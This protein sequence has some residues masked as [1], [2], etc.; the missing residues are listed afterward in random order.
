MFVDDRL[1]RLR[2][3]IDRLG[4]LPA[5]AESEWML[6]EARARLVDVETGYRP[7]AMRPLAEEPPADEAGPPPRRPA[8]APAV[9]RPAAHRSKPEPEPEPRHTARGEVRSI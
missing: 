5:S 4:Q 3:L 9:E 1:T 7:S 6:R 2:A 8:D